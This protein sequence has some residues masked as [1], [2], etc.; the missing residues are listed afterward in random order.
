VGVS[1]ESSEGGP[2]GCVP[3]PELQGGTLTC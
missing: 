1:V 3:L 2:E